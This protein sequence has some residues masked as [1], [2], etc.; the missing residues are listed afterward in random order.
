[1]GLLF[2][3]GVAVLTQLDHMKRS[4]GTCRDA[5]RWLE[6]ALR[7]KGNRL[8]LQRTAEAAPVPDVNYP[9]RQHKTAW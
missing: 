8:R 2:A 7:R 6:R 5:S 4:N 1:M 9:P 3:F